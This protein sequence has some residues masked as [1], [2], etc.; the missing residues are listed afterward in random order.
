MVFLVSDIK[1]RCAIPELTNDTYQVQSEAHAKL[2]KKY[3]P[4]EIV[5]GKLVYSKCH[6]YVNKG[7]IRKQTLTN[8]TSWVY[9]KSIFQTSLTSD[10]NLVYFIA[11]LC[12]GWLP[13]RFGRKK[14]IIAAL[15]LEGI[16]GIL[17]SQIMDINMI[18]ILRFLTAFGSSLCYMPSV[19]FGA[20]ISST[21]NRACASII[22]QL[23]LTAG[24]IVISILA[25]YIR[26]WK[27]LVLLVSIPTIPVALL[28]FWLLPESPRWLLT[29][30]KEK[31]AE[32]I[33]NKMAKVNNRNFSYKSDEIEISVVEDRTVRL[34]KI[35]TIPKLRK[36][37]FILM[38]NWFV[39]SFAYYG[40]VL[41]TE[42]LSGNIFLNF[43]FGALVEIPAYLMCVVL[44]DRIGRK[45]LYIAFMAIGGICGIMIIFS[46]MYTPGDF[47]R[48]KTSLALLS[49]LCITGS[50]GIIYLHTC[51]LYPTCVRNGALGYLS[52]FATL[53]GT[54]S[55]YIIMTRTLATGMPLISSFLKPTI[56]Q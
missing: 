29:V 24:Y 44:L 37:T 27:L 14:V 41:H 45:K 17:Y 26:T 56:N 49:R 40:M 25:Y 21:K 43:L 18:L 13:D 32:I 33:L 53:G 46:L 28:Y 15:M 3:I 7:V 47:Q 6:I 55:P 36:R 9:D 35:F 23:Y 16:T 10:S 30:K 5:D 11:M 39:V 54:I 2:I 38:F 4:E 34:W 19:V 48:N 51:E 1:H 31:E 50:Y 12:C 22:I 52:T 20:E 42:H 8:C